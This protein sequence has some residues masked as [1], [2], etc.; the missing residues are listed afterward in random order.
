VKELKIVPAEAQLN[1]G[2]VKCGTGQKNHTKIQR[3]CHW[4]DVR[5]LLLR[6]NRTWLKSFKTQ[7][8][9][10]RKKKKRQP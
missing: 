6:E 3:G 7:N 2:L 4:G 1:K 9:F 8:V 5:Y 10:Q